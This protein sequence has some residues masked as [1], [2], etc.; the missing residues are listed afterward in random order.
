MGGKN[1]GKR[2][3][4]YKFPPNSPYPS[5]TWRDKDLE[6][7]DIKELRNA[8]RYLVAGWEAA[9]SE[10]L[11]Y[12]FTGLDRYRIEELKRRDPKLASME[13]GCGGR[14]VAI[15]RVNLVRAIEEGSIKDS[16]WLLEHVDPSFQATSR[17]DG[18]HQEVLI[19]VAEKEKLVEEEMSK[20]LEGVEVEFDDES[21]KGTAGE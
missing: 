17:L 2:G 5:V 21:T 1:S 3:T 7:M 8:T 20:L 11:L 10:Q 12:D 6:E 13:V 14:L 15:A 16:R 4:K 9:L 19:P 18:R